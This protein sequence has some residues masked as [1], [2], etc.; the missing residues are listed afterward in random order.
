MTEKEEFEYKTNHPEQTDFRLLMYRYTRYWHL[1]VLGV[2]LAL[3]MAVLY[4]SFVTPQYLVSTSIKIIGIDRNPDYQA[5]SPGFR[6]LD[7]YDES[8]N[9]EDEIEALQSFSLMERVIDELDLT[10]SYFVDNGLGKDELYGD[11][12]PIKV[13]D[14]VLSEIAF[15]KEITIQIL[16]S[17][18]F[19]LEDELKETTEHRF[20]ELIKTPY[21]IFKIVATPQ[22]NSW[23]QDKKISLSFNK[24]SA[25]AIYYLD[26]ISVVQVGEESSI[27]NISMQHPVPEK[28]MDI[29]NKL[30]VLYD[31]ETKG[32][33]NRLAR[34]TL[35]FI[36]ER[37]ESV[38]A[39]LAGVESNIEQFRRKNQVTDPKADAASNL[40]E[41]RV[42]DRELS[43]LNI[44][45]DVLESLDRYLSQP[46]ERYELV[47][48]NLDIDS[49]TLLDLIER[50]NELQLE[51]ERKLISVEPTNPLLVKLNVQIENLR[52]SILE[53]LQVIKRGMLVQQQNIAQKA[54]NF[55]SRLQQAPGIEREL[56]EINRQLGVMQDLYNFLLQKREESALSLAATTSNIK[57]IDPAVVSQKPVAPNKPVVLLIAL[58]MGLCLPFAFVFAKDLLDNSIKL[59]KDVE[60][61]STSPILGEVP[62]LDKRKNWASLHQQSSPLAESIEMIISN[63]EAEISRTG[64]KAILITS[65]MNG[66]GKTFL[67]KN[68]ALS[69]CTAG[70]K[71]VLVDFDLRKPSLTAE[72]GVSNR[73][74]VDDYLEGGKTSL[75]DI[76]N[77]S[78]VYLNLPVVGPGPLP[79]NPTPVFASQRLC[80][81]FAELRERFEYI[82]IDTAPAGQVA[83][84][85]SL[86]PFADLSIYVVRYETTLKSQIGIID[87]DY[88]KKKL[89]RP[90][91]VLND[92]RKMNS[93]LVRLP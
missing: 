51:R 54:N 21:G 50:F 60:Q 39:E 37:L 11:A 91:I 36:D 77:S 41:S 53:N 4:L 23:N 40:E 55:R 27:L 63:I 7:V 2:A 79:S 14:S 93:R 86:A 84:A 85:F 15:K 72:L 73:I 5:G 46:R 3:L 17:N 70:K 56:N 42:Y 31:R 80:Q 45:I 69:L 62:H 48:S 90:L 29:L 75:N 92:A 8:T 61:L 83:D 16:D 78:E 1:F 24:V 6:R 9:L 81:L 20:G 30:V 66:E 58:A 67:S 82:I 88:V 26:Q 22:L 52:R 34:N 19:I 28:G 25:L 71:V 32:D 38:T 87:S 59:R 89:K 18:S 76:I 57:I 74:G 13:I 10:T 68:I 43:Q 47:P 44:R 35:E 12:L 49:P 33:R 64:S 65:G